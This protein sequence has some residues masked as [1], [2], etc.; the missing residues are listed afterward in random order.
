MKYDESKNNINIGMNRTTLNLKREKSED[1]KFSK[2]KLLITSL[3]FN[4]KN[5][6]S[7]TKRHLDNFNKLTSSQNK[8][9][10]NNK[11]F[12]KTQ[13]LADRNKSNFFA[14]RNQLV[15][16]AVEEI[17]DFLIFKQR[18][19]ANIDKV[20]EFWRKKVI[21]NFNQYNSLENELKYKLN[22]NRLLGIKINKETNETLILKDDLILLEEKIKET[23]KMLIKAEKDISSYNLIKEK[24]D[25]TNV[26]F[27]SFIDKELNEAKTVEGLYKKYLIIYSEANDIISKKKKSID[28]GRKFISDYEFKASIEIDKRKHQYNELEIALMKIKYLS[29]ENQVQL[30]SVLDIKKNESE[31]LEKE[32]LYQKN[33]AMACKESKREYLNMHREIYYFLKS[34]KVN[35]VD[36][37]IDNFIKISDLNK[38]LAKQYQD[39]FVE[40]KYYE[41]SALKLNEKYK[42]LYIIYKS[43]KEKVEKKY[44]LKELNN[45]ENIDFQ[46]TKSSNSI[47]YKIPN[48]NELQKIEPIIDLGENDSN[49]NKE[50]NEINPFLEYLNFKKKVDFECSKKENKNE[51]LNNN[52][53]G[54]LKEYVE[55]QK[56]MHTHLKEQE[57]LIMND[58]IEINELKKMINEV[59]DI[60][61]ILNSDIIQKENILNITFINILKIRNEKIEKI[62][63]DMKESKLFSD[64]YIAMFKILEKDSLDLEMELEKLRRDQDDKYN[65]FDEFNNKTKRSKN[66]EKLTK[67]V[68]QKFIKKNKIDEFALTSTVFSYKN[69]NEKKGFHLKIFDSSIAEDK[70]GHF[71]IKSFYLY[72]RVFSIYSREVIQIYNENILNCCKTFTY[73]IEAKIKNDLRRIAIENS[74]FNN[75]E[76]NEKIVDENEF[77][78]ENQSLSIIIYNSKEFIDV[79]KEDILKAISTYELQLDYLKNKK[80]NV[81]E[82]KKIQQ[83]KSDSKIMKNLLDT[84]KSNKIIGVKTSV[85]SVVD[86]FLESNEQYKVVK[87]RLEKTFCFYTNEL[88]NKEKPRKIVYP[89]VK[90]SFSL[91][92]KLEYSEDLKIKCLNEFKKKLDPIENINLESVLKKNYKD[93]DETINNE[94]INIDKDPA[95]ILDLLNNKVNFQNNYKKITDRNINNINKKGKNLKKESKSRHD[96][97]SHFVEEDKDCSVIIEEDS[98]DL[99]VHVKTNKNSILFNKLQSDKTKEKFKGLKALYDRKSDIFNLENNFMGQG[100][101]I[102]H[103]EVELKNKMNAIKK[104]YLG[105]NFNRQNSMIRSISVVKD[106]GNKTIVANNSTIKNNSINLKKSDS[107]STINQNTNNLKKLIND[108]ESVKN[109]EVKVKKTIGLENLNNIIGNTSKEQKEKFKLEFIKSFLSDDHMSDLR[110]NQ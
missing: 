23:K 40:I 28:D 20:E 45:D 6:S 66:S 84:T 60:N 100:L 8:N 15:N 102:N 56:E 68:N 74:K 27:Q 30:E 106:K 98:N 9:G 5:E 41:N 95:P 14:T 17:S 86:L 51:H 35:S 1:I 52:G 7:S 108:N 36:D 64:N 44:Q 19:Y 47:G 50:E 39:K 61:K 104:S 75:G 59:K 12:Y 83:I 13:T 97:K 25:K 105:N 3:D 69:Q 55:I 63:K 48:A 32:K 110:E 78:N 31:K 73:K 62:K 103:N 87:N 71:Y 80:N 91:K 37:L 67:K 90:N 43:L 29:L 21:V 77:K 33:I 18:D 57:H 38:E 34:C 54:I 53:N 107:N 81:T 85:K 89:N 109:Q 93:Q 99:K 88:L 24:E 46:N 70:K 26:K 22:K 16:S 49:F 11:T 82:D 94:K 2:D 58:G 96:I 10:F 65:E 92:D 4:E 79:L 72:H 101:E 76:L 42:Y